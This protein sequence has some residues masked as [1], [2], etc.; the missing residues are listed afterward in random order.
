MFCNCRTKCKW[1]KVLVY[2]C[3][4]LTDFLT[5]FVG[6]SHQ[7]SAG[8]VDKAHFI[9]NFLPV[10]KLL[11]SDVFIHLN[12]NT[13]TAVSPNARLSAAIVNLESHTEYNNVLP[14]G[15]VWWAACTARV[16]D[17][18]PLPLA[19]LQHQHNSVIRKSFVYVVLFLSVSVCDCREFS[20]PVSVSRICWSVS[21]SPS[22]MEVL[23]STLGLT[24]LA[25]FRTLRDWSK[26]ALG[27]RTCLKTDGTEKKTPSWVTGLLHQKD[28]YTP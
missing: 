27:S 13:H 16:L 25:C 5:C 15:G 21:P 20:T 23:V 4:L 14:W 17:G 6:G 10:G 28:K 11:W 8:C 2:V 24:F 3:V 18:R 1:N 19:A 26:F 22:M 12:P 7:W 9:P